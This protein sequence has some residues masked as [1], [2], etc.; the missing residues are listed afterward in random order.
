MTASISEREVTPN[1][2]LA[3][4]IIAIGCHRYPDGISN[5]DCCIDDAIGFLRVMT[6]RP[7]YK[8]SQSHCYVLLHDDHKAR[9]ATAVLTTPTIPGLKEAIQLAA[10]RCRDL[11]ANNMQV[12]L[13]FYFSGH[14]TVLRLRRQD[15]SSA[16]AGCLLFEDIPPHDYDFQRALSQGVD[17]DGVPPGYLP[18]S[19]LAEWLNR[20]PATRR[21]LFLDACHSGQDVQLKQKRVPF[22]SYEPLEAETVA[23]LLGAMPASC[24]FSSSTKEQVSWTG[25]TYSLW[26]QF[27]LSAF[28]GDPD[29][30]FGPSLTVTSLAGYLSRSMRDE[31]TR[32]VR[33]RRIRLL[34]T[35]SFSISMHHDYEFCRDFGGQ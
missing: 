2:G 14:G 24:I 23:Q 12:D 33:T 28:D 19:Q 18:L 20:V 21:F 3:R 11:H 9:P 29:A 6:E 7:E 5:L 10:T 31:A 16:Q 15:G 13:F 8:A 22:P 27:L 26:T 35:P 30:R 25:T 34:Q 17:K 1:A 32:A 4:V